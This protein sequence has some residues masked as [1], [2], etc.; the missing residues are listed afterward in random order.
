MVR[1]V[2]SWQIQFPQVEGGA[3]FAG[4]AEVSVINT[5]P[6]KLQIRLIPG[7]VKLVSD[8]FPCDILN[9]INK[10][11]RSSPGIKPKD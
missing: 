5:A 4:C 7:T 6:A 1:H 10:P 11:G 3:V 9:Y 8:A 2:T